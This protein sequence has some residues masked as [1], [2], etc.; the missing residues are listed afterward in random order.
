[1]Y[2]CLISCQHF[3]YAFTIYNRVSNS[4]IVQWNVQIYQL[5]WSDALSYDKSTMNFFAISIFVWHIVNSTIDLN[6]IIFFKGVT[7]Y[8]ASRLIVYDDTVKFGHNHSRYSTF[9]STTR[10]IELKTQEKRKMDNMLY[11]VNSL[12]IHT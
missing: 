10:R 3:Y 8:I 1:M 6:A 9:T 4:L 2:T 5:K 11:T 12:E 7:H